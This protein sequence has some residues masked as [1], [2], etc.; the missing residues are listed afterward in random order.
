MRCG[1]TYRGMAGIVMQEEKVRQCK[2]FVVLMQ[3]EDS[4]WERSDAAPP[5]WKLVCGAETGSTFY[6]PLPLCSFPN[7]K[8][9]LG[10][11]WHSY[12]NKLRSR[13]RN[14]AAESGQ[15]VH[16]QEMHQL[17]IAY[18]QNL[19]HKLCKKT[20][21]NCQLGTLSHKLCPSC[22]YIHLSVTAILLCHP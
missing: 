12:V 5:A 17:T 3:R 14:D 7:G 22:F 19:F 16:E 8:K 4:C 9:E 15:L 10:E 13:P 11:H 1:G 2:V 21:R 18:N 20:E 6:S